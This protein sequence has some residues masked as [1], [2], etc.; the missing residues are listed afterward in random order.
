M[1]NLSSGGVL[2]TSST[3]LTLE[4]ERESTYAFYH[5][6]PCEPAFSAMGS[7]ALGMGSA[8][9]ALGSSALGWSLGVGVG[10]VFYG[11][12]YLKKEKKLGFL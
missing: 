3:N 9:S 11:R 8:L 6:K 7:A 5:R 10:G 4:R 1:N 12:I 2:P